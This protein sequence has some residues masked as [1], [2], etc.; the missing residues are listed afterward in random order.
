MGKRP[1]EIEREIEQQ[2]EQI[3][4]RISE[5]R[6]RGSDDVDELTSRFGD[7]LNT[8]VVKQ[9][10]E[11]RP[12]LTVAGALALGVALGM[13]SES[14]SLRGLV[15]KSDQGYRRPAPGGVGDGLM[16]SLS[17]LAADE[18][19]SL[20]DRW[21]SDRRSTSPNVRGEPVNETIP[22]QAVVDEQDAVGRLI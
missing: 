5:I 17:A 14:V 13:A 1:A 8:T 21:T 4:Q 11:E 15:G 16:G 7:T 2:R 10:V 19:K 3:S 18:I 12:M 22:G 20:V 6:Q 9:T